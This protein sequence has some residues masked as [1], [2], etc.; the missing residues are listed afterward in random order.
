MFPLSEGT[1]THAHVIVLNVTGV[2]AG[3]HM[4]PSPAIN[5]KHSGFCVGINA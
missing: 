4:P 2:G 5:A 1:Y 3:V